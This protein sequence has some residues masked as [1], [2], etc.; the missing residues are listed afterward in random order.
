[1]QCLKIELQA[2]TAVTVVVVVM[3]CSTI[4]SNRNQQKQE[5]DPAG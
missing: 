2:V 5:N 4:P 3:V 1:M